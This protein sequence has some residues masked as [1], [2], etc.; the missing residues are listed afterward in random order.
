M[1]WIRNA[2][3]RVN[4]QVSAGSNA[5]LAVTRLD[6]ANN[7]LRVLPR[8]IFSMISLLWVFLITF[9]ISHPY[10]LCYYRLWCCKADCGFD[11]Y[12]RKLNIYLILYNKLK[13]FSHVFTKLLLT[14]IYFLNMSYNLSIE[15]PDI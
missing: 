3:L 5:A 7:E 8:E 12:S 1:K 15:T 11:P 9:P 2:A 4:P 6:L 10:L 14:S 13:V